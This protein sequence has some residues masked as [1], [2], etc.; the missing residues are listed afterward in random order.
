M[1]LVSYVSEQ[2]LW[3]GQE[4]EVVLSVAMGRTPKREK[5]WRVAVLG[6]GKDR[7]IW[8]KGERLERWRAS[9]KI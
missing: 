5:V 2:Q 1:G 3:F 4:M 8:P 6:E 9:G 7:T